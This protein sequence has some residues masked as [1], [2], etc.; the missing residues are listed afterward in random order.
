MN[1]N[2][3]ITQAAPKM[4][5][6]ER[7]L[8]RLCIE[9]KIP[10]VIKEGDDWSLPATAD[11]RLAEKTESVPYGIDE[12]AGVSAKKR[13]AALRRLAVVKRFEQFAS[14][15]IR[16][17]G[18]R[19]QALAVFSQK[20]DVPQ[21][22]LERWIER[23]RKEGIIGLVDGRGGLALDDAISPEVFE[24]FK[25][26]YLDERKPSVKTCW[27]NIRYINSRENRGWRIPKLGAMYSIIKR[28]IPL[29][30]QV[31]HRDGLEAYE[32]RCAPYIEINPDS[33]EPGAVWV[34]DHSQF[35]CWV[36]H[37]NRWIRPWVT[38]WQ[39]MRSRT[40]VGW[41]INSGPNQSTILLAMKRG[42]ESYGPPDSVKIDNGRDYDSEMWT[43]TTKARRKA[44]R[45]GY[46]DERMVAGIYA[47]MGVAVSFAIPYHPQA[48]RIERFF[49]TLDQQFTKTLK[50]YCGRDTESRPDALA[51]YLKSDKALRESHTLESFAEAAG[52]YIEIYNN[53]VHIGAGMEGQTP[54]QVLNS[55]A[56]RR[57]MVEGVADLLLR[58]WSGELTVGK[59]GVRFHD[60][61]Y[62]QF[63][64][65]LLICQGKKVRVSYDPDD[66]RSVHVY[67]AA[68]MKLITIAEQ[69]HLVNYG[70]AVGEEDLRLAMREKAKAVKMVKS[71]CDS[72]L[73]ANMD[74]TSLTLRALEE[75][76]QAPGT[77]SAEA[78]RP[79][80]TAMDSQVREHARQHAVKAVRKAAGAEGTRTVLDIDFDALKRQ[81]EKIIDLN[82]E[83]PGNAKID[84]MDLI[85]D[86]ES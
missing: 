71:Y 8:R 58:T 15:C 38:A 79:V 84:F 42:V 36:Q 46:I 39:D 72:Q 18:T 27:Q 78:I 31:L 49:D 13:E 69:N 47:M 33:I 34:G 83:L 23:L 5:M 2:L 50:T 60:M 63:N 24:L 30:V 3:T 14:A 77:E 70:S 40:I 21:R 37:R 11:A 29:P 26:L 86:D 82:F 54:L 76:T 57:V 45:K 44:L 19:K 25:S 51:D 9:G 65:E 20:E 10:G 61:Y 12:I 80:K 85:F 62:G 73:T 66:I 17:G 68:T 22:T 6:S 4:G 32:A 75:G 81:P 7:H 67:D 53:S 43:G 28:T 41:D 64:N 48:K 59:N 74:L 56:S 16:E 1:G 52:R 35:N 55:R